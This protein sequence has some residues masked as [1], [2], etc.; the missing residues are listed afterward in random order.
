[1][2][3]ADGFAVMYSAS[4]PLVFQRKHSQVR[5]TGNPTA[6]AFDTNC[7]STIPTYLALFIF[8]FFFD[9]AMSWDAIR[10]QNTIQ[11]PVSK[12]RSDSL[13]RSLA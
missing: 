1:M 3:F 8:A 10:R 5:P 7:S 6:A 13:P 12:N 9:I 2:L 4:M 11:V